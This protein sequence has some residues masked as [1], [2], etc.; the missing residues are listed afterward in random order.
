MKRGRETHKGSLRSSSM[1]S[2]GSVCSEGSTGG[3]GAQ[4]PLFIGEETEAQRGGVT[5]N[6]FLQLHHSPT[7]TLTPPTLP[8]I[9]PA[10]LSLP[11]LL[12]AIT[13]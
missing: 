8:H 6:L 12:R 7:T 4:C 13:S 10:S 1:V 2:H 5:Y 11:V 9:I 3:H